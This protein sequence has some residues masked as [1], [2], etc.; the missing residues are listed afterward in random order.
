MLDSW[1]VVFGPWP[2]W[3]ILD[4]LWL[5]IFSI[6]AR[7]TLGL[8]DVSMCYPWHLVI[9]LGLILAISPRSL[10]LYVI[11]NTVSMIIYVIPNTWSLIPPGGVDHGYRPLHCPLLPAHPGRHSRYSW[12]VKKKTHCNWL[13]LNCL[14]NCYVDGAADGIRY[15]LTPQWH[16]LTERKV[17]SVF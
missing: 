6:L 7:F 16:K 8:S 17:R 15:Y 3:L 14:L 4:L 2:F 11:P 1:A 12:Q 10:I 13:L 9:F 5:S